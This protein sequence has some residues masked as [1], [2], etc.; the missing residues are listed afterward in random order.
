MASHASPQPTTEPFGGVTVEPDD[1]GTSQKSEQVPAGLWTHR[2]AQP[3]TRASSQAT[4]R[5]A[6]PSSRASS[7]ATYSSARPLSRASSKATNRSA[8]PSSRASSKATYS[9]ARPLSR[10]SSQATDSSVRRLGKR[11]S[12]ENQPRS[13]SSATLDGIVGPVQGANTRPIKTESA[14]PG[15]QVPAA[16]GQ[17]PSS[18]RAT[19]QKALCDLYSGKRSRNKRARQGTVVLDPE[20]PGRWVVDHHRPNLIEEVGPLS[21]NPGKGLRRWAPSFMRASWDKSYEKRDEGSQSPQRIFRV[22]FAE[23]QRMHLRKLQ[24]E[25]VRHAVTMYSTK[26][27]SRKWEEILAAYIQALRDYDYMR[28]YSKRPRDNFLA[29]GERHIDR[30]VTRK[31]IKKVLGGYDELEGVSKTTPVGPWETDS[32]PIG[33]TRRSTTK[34]LLLK[35]SHDR[36][37]LAIAGAVLLLGPMWLMVLHETLYTGLI[38]TT[39]CVAVFGL[40]VVNRLE[41]PMDVLSA[42]AAYAAVLVVFVGLTTDNS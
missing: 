5:S 30:Y 18:L 36:L 23:M 21:T 13:T 17:R 6:R 9:S 14:N 31:V 20:H 19:I 38:T 41:K 33:E 25:L 2:P 10:A 11:Y 28:E 7:K 37:L 34:A 24:I 15:L 39:V 12:R 29:T 8:R 16:S 35:E 40:V 26:R 4:N 22:S 27:E 1:F 32:R 3:L 42:T